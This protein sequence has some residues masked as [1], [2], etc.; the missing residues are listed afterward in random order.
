MAAI[1]IKNCGIRV[2][3]DRDFQIDRPFGSGD[4][5]LLHFISPVVVR[6]KD[7]LQTVS[8]NATIVYTPKFPQYY[9]CPEDRIDHSWLHCLG[10]GMEDMIQR[11]HIPQNTVMHI[12]SL[13]EL[14]PFL[15]SVRHEQLYREPYWEE[16]VAAKT[17]E[18]FLSLGRT[19]LKR[20]ITSLTP[21]QDELQEGIR[22]A[23]ATAHSDLAR[24][25]TVAEMAALAN[26][27]TSR[28]TALYSR[29]YGVSPIDDLI[30][31]RIRQAM[32]L[33]QTNSATV[34]TI[35]QEC[36]FSSPEH[37]SRIFRQRNG[38]SPRDYRQISHRNAGD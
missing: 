23:R 21:Y 37:F 3:H 25:W 11:Y 31:S 36:G 6:D 9:H 7:G 27:S 17:E 35:A 18:F 22:N 4:Y 30:A 10:D 32:F 2:R 24:R 20:H 26:L 16:S 29:F 1:T 13:G 14:T 28:F 34:D 33:L 19:I 12:G 15:Q 5:V 38:S 8:S